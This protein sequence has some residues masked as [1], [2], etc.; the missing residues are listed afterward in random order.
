[1]RVIFIVIIMGLSF[2]A[3]PLKGHE[4]ELFQSLEKEKNEDEDF[5]QDY[6]LETWWWPW[7]GN[8]EEENQGSGSDAGKSPFSSQK[9][10]GLE[11]KL[12]QRLVGQDLAIKITVSALERYA[13]GLNEPNAPIAS[14]LYVGPSGVGKTQLAKELAKILLGHERALIHL[15]MSEY[16]ES[17]SLNRL[18]GSPPGYIDHKEGGQFTNA[19]KKNP[20]AIV[21]LDEIE[22]ASPVVLKLFLQ[23]FDEG[24]ITDSDGNLIDCRN[25]M[26][27]LTTNLESQ[28]ILTMH[29]LGHSDQ[30]IGSAIQPALIKSLSPE[31]YNRL[32]PVLFRG[33]KDH[34]IGE[35]IHVLLLQ[36]T[37]EMNEKKQIALEF[38]PGIAQFLKKHA[39]HYQLGARPIKHL[40][41]QTVMTAITE[42][43]KS[44]FLQKEAKGTINCRD[45]RFTIQI[46]G[47]SEPFV[48][49]WNEEKQE[50]KPPFQLEDLIH[51][52]S[53]LQSKILG[54]PYAIKLTVAALLRYAAGLT[55]EQSP[56]GAFLYVGP[57]GVGKTQLA[58]ELTLELMGSPHHL[59]R[60]DMSQYA[61]EGAI[62]RLIGSPPGCV[63][64]HEGGQLTEALKQN[65]YAIVLLDEIEKA[66]PAVLKTFL[67]VFD[68]GRIMDAK[69]T[70]IDCR[71]V[72]FIATTN[73][74]SAKILS[75][76]QEGHK[77][78]DVLTAIQD[79][80]S[81]FISPELYNRFEVA[82]FM[83][84]SSE[85]LE[86][87]IEKMLKEVQEEL[88]TK[89]GIDVQ[90]DSKII[91][92]LKLHGYDYKLGAR[93]LK[94]LIQQ[95]LVTS[96]A[97]EVV[98]KKIQFGDRLNLS[99]E[100]GEVIIKKG[101]RIRQD[102]AR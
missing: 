60:L 10:I 35:L 59:I 43:M 46:T 6:F 45:S 72:I 23:L 48:W 94:R 42:A 16:A 99:Y 19:L 26:F 92:F 64:H 25:V 20:Y 33:F 56:I 102:Q 12:Q 96:I 95:T 49:E 2:L 89:K 8:S 62:S 39:V 54:Q 74:A 101:N 47:K 24:L 100:D 87:L 81:W 28:K 21:L 14:L 84:L 73:L 36:V 88:L 3:S 63:D 93:P 1:M 91:E 50:G 9:L 83:G 80:I 85:L 67:Q 97:K 90:F 4:L 38:E 41:R 11:K 78:E 79:E 69:G 34:L 22:K 86:Q 37:E 31:L 51:L 30:E 82:V 58:K 70:L 13:Y 76:H 65:P 68:E 75:M 71:N 32:E 57:T 17:C 53:R 18:I 5:I 52:E 77:E 55:N 61:H 66:H 44:G 98:G 27:I 29:E 7:G 40:I 15:N